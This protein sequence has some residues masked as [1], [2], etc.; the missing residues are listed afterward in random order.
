MSYIGN[1]PIVSATR[2]V[3]ESTATAGQ[4]TFTANG[5]YTVGFIDVFVNGSQLQSSDFTATNG[6]TI[7]LNSGA[8]VGDDIRLVAYGTFSVANTYT[9]ANIDSKIGA[10]QFGFKNRLIDGGFIINQRV[11]VSGT[12]LSAGIYAHDR[13]KAGASGCTY[14]F[15]QGSLGVPITITITAGSLQ[16]IIEGCNMPDGGSYVLSW[17]GTAQARINGG[18]YGSSPLTVSGL[19]AGANCTVEFNTGTVLKPQLEVGSVATSFDYRP[20][21]TE[22]ALCQRYYFKNAP[23]S[24]ADAGLGSGTQTGTTN[25]A[26]LM[27]LPVQMRSAPTLT[28]SNTIISDNSTFDATATSIDAGYFGAS[29]GYANIAFASAGAAFRPVLFRAKSSGSIG[30]ISFSAEL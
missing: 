16:Q 29:S 12:S 27:N 25:A 15:T 4:T 22:L 23:S 20:Y 14:T 18:T 9:A 30:F 8:S 3:T 13:W 17:S 5:G 11:Y 24:I 10:A 19:T 6:S 7:T 2:T 1:E 26:I 28:Q 21:G